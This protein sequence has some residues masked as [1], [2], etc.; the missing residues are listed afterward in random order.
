[1]P[2]LLPTS[3]EALVEGIQFFIHF[4]LPV[5][6]YTPSIQAELTSRFIY[7]QHFIEDLLDSPLIRRAPSK[8]L[9]GGDRGCVWLVRALILLIFNFA[10][11]KGDLV[12]PFETPVNYDLTRL[13]LDELTHMLSWF[14][15]VI[16]ALRASTL[17]L[18]GSS[19]ARKSFTP[20]PAPLHGSLSVPSQSHSL[21]SADLMDSSTSPLAATSDSPFAAQTKSKSNKRQRCQAARKHPTGMPRDESEG[22]MSSGAS[23]KSIVEPDFERLDVRSDRSSDL[24]PDGYWR[25]FDLRSPQSPLGRG[26][27]ASLNTECERVERITGPSTHRLQEE[28]LDLFE[29]GT[30]ILSCLNQC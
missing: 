28:C 16:E 7:V 9:V 14:R 18:A 13:P 17:V 27:S 15:Q 19:E 21:P 6:Y 30:P 24:D 20:K 10:A 26:C 2:A 8:T 12:P 29:L 22:S 23:D 5:G 4:W 11:V 3:P 25:D 1:M